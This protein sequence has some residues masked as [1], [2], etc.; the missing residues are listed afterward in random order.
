MDEVALLRKETMGRIWKRTIGAIGGLGL[1][2][3]AIV[4]A[5]AQT[6]PSDNLTPEVAREKIVESNR[7]WGKARV[8]YDRAFMEAAL[9]PEFYVQIGDRRISRED[10]ID[11]CSTRSPDVKLTRF[12]VE[13]L[14]VQRNREGGWVAVIA[15]KLEIERKNSDGKPAK[16]YSLWVTRDSYRVSGGKWLCTSSEASGFESWQDKKPPFPNW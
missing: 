4:Y 9:P 15:E 13:V 8:N 7:L 1:G 11:Q 12:D 2:A 14:T 6:Q 16:V 10:F 5:Q 3:A